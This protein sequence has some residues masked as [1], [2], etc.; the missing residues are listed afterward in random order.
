MI[1]SANG[2]SFVQSTG[3]E[4]VNGAG[5]VSALLYPLGNVAGSGVVDSRNDRTWPRSYP[6]DIR[7]GG[8]DLERVAGVNAQRSTSPLS[9]G[10]PVK[11]LQ[12]ANLAVI[13]GKR[14]KSTAGDENS[15]RMYVNID[16]ASST[17]AIALPGRK[18][19][20]TFLKAFYR[21]GD[22]GDSN[23]PI[24]TSLEDTNT[25][26]TKAGSEV[27]IRGFKY[28][29]I[30]AL[31]TYTSCVFRQDRYGQF[32]DMLEQRPFTAIQ[33]FQHTAQEG[34]E[35]VVGGQKSACVSVAFKKAVAISNT[36]VQVQGFTSDD[37]TQIENNSVGPRGIWNSTAN[38]DTYS[39]TN[40][41]FY[42]VAPLNTSGSIDPGTVD[43]S[44]L[45]ELGG[46]TGA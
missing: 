5:T 6:F 46:F 10:S 27:Q 39:R 43:A 16:Y 26:Q 8:N 37:L 38:I 24:I 31:P 18:Q 45:F 35:I 13:L 28:G 9:S 3:A 32:R 36:D 20:K 25:A 44:L 17:S 41:P 33:K 22:S 30:S 34:G 23:L 2:K 12:T 21:F 15:Q 40:R 11:A 7:Y 29:L 14:F 1:A 19:N 42:D 4:I